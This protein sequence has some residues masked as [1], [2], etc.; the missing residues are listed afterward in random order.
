MAKPEGRRS[1]GAL[2]GAGNNFHSMLNSNSSNA[3]H[4]GRAQGSDLE[5]IAFALEQVLDQL[6]DLALDAA[7]AGS[8]LAGLADA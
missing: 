1:R 2:C 5:H 6:E 7:E 3:S 8:P 4:Y